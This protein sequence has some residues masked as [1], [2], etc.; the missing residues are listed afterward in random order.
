MGFLS[1]LAE[2]KEL[3]SEVGLRSHY[4]KTNYQK[5]KAVIMEYAQ[6][7]K[8]EVRH[9]DDEHKELFL[10]ASKYHIIVSFVQVTPYE[11]SVDFKVEMYTMLGFNRP[12]KKIMALYEYLDKQLPYKGVGLH[13]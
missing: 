2:S 12:K 6:K 5:A 7:N 10:Q 1:P 8:I 13:P 4:Y 3:H 9:I 11:T